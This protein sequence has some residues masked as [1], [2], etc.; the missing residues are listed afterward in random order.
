MMETKTDAIYLSASKLTIPNY[1]DINNSDGNPL[2][3]TVKLNKK[4]NSVFATAEINYDGY[5][6]INATARNDWS[7][8]LAVE[9]RSYFYPS[10]STSLVVTDMINKLGGE[11]HKFYHLLN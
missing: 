10:V 3:Q 9:N 1:F 2:I 5:W 4:I 7:S 11:D 6:F 8:T